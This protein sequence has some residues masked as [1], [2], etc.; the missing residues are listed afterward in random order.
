MNGI[1]LH[2]IAPKPDLAESIGGNLDLRWTSTRPQDGVVRSDIPAIFAKKVSG[3][4]MRDVQVDWA[5]SM[6]EYFSEGVRV[7]EFKDLTI[8]SYSGRQAQAAGAAIVLED[9][10]GVAITNSRAQPGTGN[11]SGF[12]QLHGDGASRLRELRSEWRE[13]RN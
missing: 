3:L 1:R 9:G 7:E 8:D 13:E 12:A 6:P 4:R 5:D 10:S 2:M 11:L